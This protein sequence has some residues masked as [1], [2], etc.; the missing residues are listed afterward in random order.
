MRYVS[1]TK[2]AIFL[3]T[4]K[5]RLPKA[6]FVNN[7]FKISLLDYKQHHRADIRQVAI[8]P[9]WGDIM[10]SSSQ[11]KEVKVINFLI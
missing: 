9:E 7:Y 2:Q 5:V 4:K 1:S 10:V 6:H 3:F 11:D 8:L